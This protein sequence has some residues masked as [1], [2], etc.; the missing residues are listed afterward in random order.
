MIKI[1]H[2]TKR[3]GDTV[4][5]D[6]LNF[7]VRPGVVTGFL[8]PNGS[9]KSTTM[10]IILGLDHAT[11]G[12]A[13]VN[14]QDY[15]DLKA[16]LREVGALLDAKAV[17]P[18][19]TA[20]NHLRA[21]AAS[22][23]I[24]KSRVDEVLDFAGITTVADKRV[25]GFSLGMSQRLGIAGALLG[26]PGILLFDEPV[27]GLDPEGIRWIREFFRSLANEGRTVFVSSHLMSEMAVSA[28]QIIVIGR[29]RFITQGSVDA[30]TKTAQGSVLVRSSDPTKLRDALVARRAEVDE[31]SD[32]NFTV[33]GLTSDEVGE[34]AF[35]AEI[36]LYELT[37]Q[38]ASLEEVFM[39]LTADS[40][41]YGHK[42][43]GPVHE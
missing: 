7:E 1:D 27:N 40:V 35:A 39:D 25:G 4:A 15:A 41:E 18:G 28:D 42:P 17:H 37:P 33:N 43:L 23:Q 21:L 10:R 9:G 6:D 12:R 31:S 16:P 32:G 11:K 24:A 14:G 5:I 20:R 13:T 38:R 30:L 8:G 19:R 3:Y 36:T 2:L 26:D 22:N 29:G 34:I